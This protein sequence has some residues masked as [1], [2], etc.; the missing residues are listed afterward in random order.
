MIDLRAYGDVLF[1]IDEVM[2][3][4]Y[5]ELLKFDEKYFYSQNDFNRAFLAHMFDIEPKSI[6]LNETKEL[7]K[8]PIK[9]YFNE[10]TFYSLNKA[11]KSFYSECEIKEWF[12]YGGKP[13][14]FKLDL[15]ASKTGIGKESLAKTDEIITTFKNARSV[16]DGA[17]IQ[18]SSKAKTHAGIYALQGENI[19][20]MPFV[21]REIKNKAVISYANTYKQD[22]IISLKL[23]LKGVIA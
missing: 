23:N 5:D 3:K 10:G 2:T 7:L 4:K 21:L 12:N 14:H 9:T 19:S 8:E 6:N 17:N 11:L 20:V 15:E 16:Y 18:I 1:R 22:E 13:Y